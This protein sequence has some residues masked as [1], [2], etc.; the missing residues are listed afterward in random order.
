MRKRITA[1]GMKKS[2]LWGRVFILFYVTANIWI[3]CKLIQLKEY[4]DS[5]S[6]SYPT[7]SISESAFDQWKA[8]ED[9]KMFSGAAV[10]KKDSK[11]KV[12][13][14]DTGR[15]KEV[16]CYQV[17]GQ[18]EAIFGSSLAEGRYFTEG[19]EG[20][21]LL[22]QVTAHVLFGSD[23]VSGLSIRMNGDDLRIVGILKEDTAVCMVPAKKDTV[24]DGIAVRKR[25][26]GQSS[27][28]AVSFMESV[29]GSAN[30]QMIDGQH[31]YV[32]AWLLY[33]G[34]TGVVLILAGN[35]IKSR[36]GKTD[37]VLCRTKVG[38]WLCMAGAA[39]MLVL[40][41]K[42]SNPGSDYLPTFW[43]DFEFFGELFRE[44]A[45]QIQ[46]LIVHQEF[47]AWQRMLHIW[48]QTIG[49]ELIVLLCSVLIFAQFFRHIWSTSK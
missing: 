9:S 7:G 29:L 44:K 12:S 32:T 33:A 30:G 49:G 31:Y 25:E 6:L 39:G 26:R 14:E 41:V 1:M 40:G 37:N 15:E 28:Q 43:S 24:F 2:Q 18:P 35:R 34:I 36:T 23:H 48:R 10:W 46:E 4:A 21:C 22:D 38:F 27:K 17:K 47:A 45:G 11:Y 5:L 16:S 13:S 19:E 3:L 8:N 42:A 20:V